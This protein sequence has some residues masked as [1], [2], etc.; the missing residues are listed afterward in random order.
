MT[1]DIQ[2]DWIFETYPY[3]SNR[4]L[5]L[6]SKFFIFKVIYSLREPRL[7]VKTDKTMDI[8]SG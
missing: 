8:L 1:R 4:I 6:I 2:I 7:L 5:N 3:V